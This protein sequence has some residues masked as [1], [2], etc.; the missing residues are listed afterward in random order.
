MNRELIHHTE[1]LRK[2]AEGAWQF[3]SDSTRDGCTH[4]TSFKADG[5][6]FYL[7]AKPKAEDKW[8][9]VID[10]GYLCKFWDN[11]IYGKIDQSGIGRL[12][13]SPSVGLWICDNEAEY[14]NCEVLR[15]KGIK[16]PYFQGD[17]IP[18]IKSAHFVYFKGGFSCVCDDYDSI[19]WSEVIAYI[20]V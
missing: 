5:Q 4:W 17:D 2:V 16:Q 1:L 15:E 3:T 9:R 18:E 10:E 7:Y 19:D 13:D 20:E 12:I 14:A 11:D 6:E 8:Q